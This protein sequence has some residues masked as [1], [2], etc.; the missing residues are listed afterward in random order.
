MKK[1]KFLVLLG[2]LTKSELADFG[3]YLRRSYSKNLLALNTFD[4]LRK[5]HP[6][7][8]DVRKMDLDYI[9]QKIFGNSPVD[10]QKNRKYLLNIFHDM[11]VWLKEF[12]IV[13]K[14]N[15][16]S[17]ESEHLWLKILH[18]KNL[19]T[20]YATAQ[21]AIFNRIMKAPQ[22][23][24]LSHIQQVV[25]CY[26]SYYDRPGNK[27]GNAAVLLDFLSELDSFNR[28]AS[29]KARCEI[30]NYNN[31]VNP[32]E[33]ITL[34]KATT[35]P[36]SRPLTQ[37]YEG[38]FALL[39]GGDHKDFQHLVN[40][41][42][43]Y[44]DDITKDELL[45]VFTYLKN[46]LKTPINQ[47]IYTAWEKAHQLDKFAL[48][49]GLFLVENGFMTMITFLNIVNAACKVQAYKWVEKFVSG[50]IHEMEPAIQNDMSKLALALVH[51]EKKEFKLVLKK[52]KPFEV[53]KP[54]DIHIMVRQMLLRLISMYELNA[55]FDEQIRLNFNFEKYLQR[56]SSFRMTTKKEVILFLHF[57]RKLLMQKKKKETMTPYNICF[58]I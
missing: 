44:K 52:L 13:R 23:D 10:D 47:G 31:H 11:N 1:N 8:D 40:G 20:E 53:H 56:N 30:L 51:Y 36:I 21:R 2:S 48:Q 49:E 29:L 4:Y 26:L 27:P 5:F 22:S 50:H 14:A 45:T 35:R 19:E 39:S 28:T 15:D 42:F 38:A 18:S 12:L 25:A 9:A 33:Q 24:T 54:K 7:F 16:G 57:L 41:M 58:D 46:S 37:L 3:K 6:E 34:A 32:T 43:K 17:L 55:E